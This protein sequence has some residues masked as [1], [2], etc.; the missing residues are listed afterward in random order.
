[1]ESMSVKSQTT[2]KREKLTDPRVNS[3]ILILVSQSMREVLDS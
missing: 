3:G 2:N 1:M